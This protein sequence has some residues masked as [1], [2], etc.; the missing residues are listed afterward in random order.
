[1]MDSKRSGA[2]LNIFMVTKIRK[3]ILN[4]CKFSKRFSVTFGF[5]SSYYA[6]HIIVRVCLDSSHKVTA[7]AFSSTD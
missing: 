5:I 7:T 3:V 4:G 1:M 6:V 2:R